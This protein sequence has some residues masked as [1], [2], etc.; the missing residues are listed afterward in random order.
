M[1]SATVL[2][3]GDQLAS[4]AS[5]VARL[6]DIAKT[7]PS[8]LAFLRDAT[9]VVQC[10]R[11]DLHPWERQLYGD[12][13]DIRDLTCRHESAEHLSEAVGTTLITIIQ[14]GELLLCVYRTPVC[15]YERR[16]TVTGQACRGRAGHPWC[17]REPDTWD[18]RMYRAA[19]RGCG[20]DGYHGP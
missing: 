10:L 6:Y 14:L 9:D 19:G 16:L 4:K 17:Q 3:F 20:G 1:Q 5:A 11:Q 12:F 18:R 15:A 13:A 2:L 8:L 7:R